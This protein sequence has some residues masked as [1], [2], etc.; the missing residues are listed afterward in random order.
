MTDL[1]RLLREELPGL[2]PDP[3]TAPD[4]AGH[5][6]SIHV[7]RARRRTA[8]VVAGAVVVAGALVGT[9]ALAGDDAPEPVSPTEGFTC[10]ERVTDLGGS[11]AL[12][13]DPVAV[14]LCAWGGP[15]GYTIQEP[16]DALVEHAD[17]LARTINALPAGPETGDACSD[18]TGPGFLLVFRYDDGSERAVIGSDYGCAQ[19]QVVGGSIHADPVEARRAFE[20]ALHTQRT[21][22]DPPAEVSAPDLTCGE[23]V[24]SDP[25]DPEPISLAD[26]T[27]VDRA[28]VCFQRYRHDGTP[29]EVPRAVQLNADELARV[30]Q[31]W[32]PAQRGGQ[33]ITG[34]CG[35]GRRPRLLGSSPWGELLRVDLC[36]AVPGALDLIEQLDARAVPE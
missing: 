36:S 23:S 12:R 5:A 14:R 25:N 11:G 18:S 13:E 4:R 24:L 10:P 16:V 31:E 26:I 32:S 3:P 17:V 35:P 34:V 7:A 22:T 27:E 2:V 29:L 28:I 21:R 19:L 33:P 15:S 9:L 8:A 30:R 20:S 6:R 1:E